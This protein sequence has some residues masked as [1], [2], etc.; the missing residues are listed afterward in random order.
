MISHREAL[1]AVQTLVEYH[2]E[3]S[4]CQ[5]CIFRRF[6]SEHWNCQIEAYDLQDVLSNLAAKKKNNGYL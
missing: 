1:D 2:K 6:G 4:G 5:N 3:Q